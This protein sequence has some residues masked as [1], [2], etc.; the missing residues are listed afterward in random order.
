[1]RFGIVAASLALGLAATAQAAEADWQLLRRAARASYQLPL[2]GT[3]LHQSQGVLE[4][5]QLYR[6]AGESGVV[7][8]HESLD[9]PAREIVRKGNALTCYAPDKKS[10]AAAKISSMRLFPGFLP[11]GLGDLK[12][13][14]S[15]RRLDDDRVAQR[16]C[17]WLQLSPKDANRYSLRLCVDAGTALPLKAM[18]L[19]PRGEVVEQ[20][21]FT[22]LEVGA[23]QDKSLLTPRN[24]RYSYQLRKAG[25]NPLAAPSEAEVATVSGLPQGFKL[26]RTVKRSLPGS[27]KNVRHMVLSDGLA[28]VSLFV[29][30]VSGDAR[31]ERPV[32]LH[33]A[34]GMVSRVDGDQVLT[35]V[36]DMPEQGLANLLK[37][38][39]IKRP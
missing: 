13:S 36:G 5:F 8:R 28:V 12:L 2:S 3:Y 34:V 30:P 16:D 4:S 25:A 19:G 10:L 26:V 32:T 17:G 31:P 35:V 14:Y 11:E 23:P 38:I 24:T 15:L 22:D 39:R 1:M 18:V 6:D 21:A 27:S 9:G 29:E 7:E 37:T 33:G 20:H